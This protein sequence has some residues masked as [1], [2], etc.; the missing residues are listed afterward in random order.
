VERQKKQLRKDEMGPQKHW[1]M[2]VNS[3]TANYTLAE[4]ES[5][6]D[7]LSFVTAAAMTG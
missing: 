3:I 1:K 7:C 5:G 2:M 6:H 4:N